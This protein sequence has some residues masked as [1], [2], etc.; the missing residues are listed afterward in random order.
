[1]KLCSYMYMVYIIDCKINKD[2]Q[3]FIALCT[4]IMKYIW[5]TGNIDSVTPRCAS[6]ITYIVLA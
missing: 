1:M 4:I 2:I 3:C 6:S 5:I